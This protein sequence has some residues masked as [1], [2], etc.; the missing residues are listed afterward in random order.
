MGRYLAEA[1]LLQN[2]KVG[3][4]KLLGTGQIAHTA[5]ARQRIGG[6]REAMCIA[7]DS[8]ASKQEQGRKILTST[9][10]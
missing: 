6:A 8:Q 5:G 7:S 10:Y 9:L 1:T 2:L 3:L 4:G